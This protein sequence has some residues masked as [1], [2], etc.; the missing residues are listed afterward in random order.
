MQQALT[1]T[2]VQVVYS[3]AAEAA[4]VAEVALTIQAV[5]VTV[6]RQAV[7]V[8][9]VPPLLAMVMGVREE[10]APEA[11]SGFGLTDEWTNTTKPSRTIR[12]S[13]TEGRLPAVCYGWLYY[14]D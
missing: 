13:R 8:A 5:A 14:M 4:E 9:V 6:E 11:K 10:T 1:V 2:L 3:D 12:L 7:E